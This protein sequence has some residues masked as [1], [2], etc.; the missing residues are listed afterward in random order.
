MMVFP[1]VS[2]CLER[3]VHHPDQGETG[4]RG[5]PVPASCNCLAENYK[6][7]GRIVNDFSDERK[8]SP[9]RFKVPIDRVPAAG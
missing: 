8:G 7:A 2:S 5:E 9:S 1:R 6:Q 4:F 3:A